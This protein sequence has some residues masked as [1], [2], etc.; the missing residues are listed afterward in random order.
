MIN[1]D[2]I[3]SVLEDLG[4]KLR[5]KGPYWAVCRSIQGAETTRQ[6][7]RFTKTAEHGKTM[8]MTLRF[9]L[10]DSF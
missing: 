7:Y 1:P 3:R 4:Y 6:H 5:D 8:L 9:S 2:S 10:L